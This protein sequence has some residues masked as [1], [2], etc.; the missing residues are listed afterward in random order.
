M[1]ILNDMRNGTML[2]RGRFAVKS[3][4]WGVWNAEYDMDIADNSVEVKDMWF[5]Y[6]GLQNAFVKVENKQDLM[7][8]LVMLVDLF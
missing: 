1:E 6:N 7:K 4:L 8:V 5:S 2:R 3:N